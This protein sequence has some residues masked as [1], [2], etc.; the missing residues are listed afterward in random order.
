MVSGVGMIDFLR[1]QSLEEVIVDAELIGYA[2]RFGSG[3][4]IVRYPW[5]GS[6]ADDPHQADFLE[7]THTGIGLQ[8]NFICLH[9]W[10]IAVPLSS[11]KWRVVW[12]L[13][14]E[15]TT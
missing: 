14:K 12:L 9:P 1:C 7:R 2:R 5:T 3:M 13:I 8:R 15:P 11:G 4:T 6:T 10:W